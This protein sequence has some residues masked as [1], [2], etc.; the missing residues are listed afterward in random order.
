MKKVDRYSGV[1]IYGKISSIKIVLNQS[2]ESQVN[3]CC[4]KKTT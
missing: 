2:D 4:N 3:D 1:N